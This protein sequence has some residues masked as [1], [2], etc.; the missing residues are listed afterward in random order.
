VMPSGRL[1]HGPRAI[2]ASLDAL[3]PRGVPLAS[4]VLALPGVPRAADAV[5]GWVARNRMRFPGVPACG[6]GRPPD[7]LDPATQ[8]EIERRV[9]PGV[10]A[11]RA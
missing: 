5:Y 9:E 8:V 6:V 7:V 1:R 11:R 4:A 3:M 2:L 10:G